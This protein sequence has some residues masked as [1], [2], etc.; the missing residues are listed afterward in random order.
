MMAAFKMVSLSLSQPQLQTQSP[1]W[2]LRVLLRDYCLHLPA[3]SWSLSSSILLKEGFEKQ[4]ENPI[5]M[6]SDCI[7]NRG[8]VHL[9]L[10]LTS[11]VFP[12]ESNNNLQLVAKQDGSFPRITWVAEVNS[13]GNSKVKR[14]ELLDST[15]SSQLTLS[16]PLSMIFSVMNFR[17]SYYPW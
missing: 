8:K 9:V 15:Y 11:F 17:Y 13:D 14:S 10:S 2:L 1:A 12:S 6:W 16:T 5:D 3:I 4:I 7:H